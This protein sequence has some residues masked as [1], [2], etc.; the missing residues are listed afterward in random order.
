MEI[1]LH[2]PLT[3]TH[4]H[5]HTL[6]DCIQGLCSAGLLCLTSPCRG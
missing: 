4:T 2:Y 6:S 5:T 1:E 3:H